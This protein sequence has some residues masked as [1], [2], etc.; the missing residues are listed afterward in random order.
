MRSI[1][2]SI[3]RPYDDWTVDV[4]DFEIKSIDSLIYQSKT[5][6]FGNVIVEKKDKMPNNLGQ[7]KE[8]IKKDMYVIYRGVYVMGTDVMLEWGIAK[9]MIKPL[10]LF[11][12][13]RNV[14]NLS[15]KQKSTRCS[16]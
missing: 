6:K 12:R 15:C 3:D 5:N 13:I 16:F 7:N 2:F 1:D 8:I 10:S 4:I 11:R 14:S 9:N